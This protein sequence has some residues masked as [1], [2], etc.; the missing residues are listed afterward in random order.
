MKK[1]LYIFIFAVLTFGLS[2]TTSAQSPNTGFKK[3][4]PRVSQPSLT[5]PRVTSIAVKQKTTVA[6]L[7]PASQKNLTDLTARK[8][9]QTSKIAKDTSIV[10]FVDGFSF[11]VGGSVQTE[12]FW[13]NG[14]AISAFFDVFTELVKKGTTIYDVNGKLNNSFVDQAIDHLVQF[15]ALNRDSFTNNFRDI[16]D[17]MNDLLDGYVGNTMNFDL[18]N[19]LPNKIIKY[20]TVQ[21]LMEMAAVSIGGGGGAASLNRLREFAEALPAVVDEMPDTFPDADDTTPTED[22]ED[23]DDVATSSDDFW[24]DPNPDHFNIFLQNYIY[25]FINYTIITKPNI[26]TMISN[27]QSGRINLQRLQMDVTKNMSLNFAEIEW[28]VKPEKYIPKP[29]KR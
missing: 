4:K 19:I 5:N 8:V 2:T 13:N 10:K 11:V 24:I 6:L 22:E 1:V 3:F 18:S 12:F 23:D 27:Y 20:M 16:I 21:E 17:T 9:L 7:L 29:M 25:H 26:R 28:T 14:A 15:S